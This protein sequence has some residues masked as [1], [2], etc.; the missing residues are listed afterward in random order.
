M[1]DIIEMVFS[2]SNRDDI[3]TYL[4]AMKYMYRMALQNK[5]TLQRFV[6]VCSA[7]GVDY[8]QLL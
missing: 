5:S 4:T 6:D 7:F 2:T 8:D 1:N 3:I